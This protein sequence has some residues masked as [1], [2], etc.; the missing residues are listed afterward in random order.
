MDNTNRISVKFSNKIKPIEAINSEFTLCKCYV[1]GCG[2]NRNLT[3]M[4]KENV[5]KFKGT[6]SYTPVVGHLFKDDECNLHMGGHD[7]TFD[8]NFN[9]VALTVPFGVVKADSFAYETV[10][11]YGTDFEY[12][13]ADIVLWTGRYPELKEAIYNDETWFNQSMEISVSQYRPLEEDSNYTELLDW[14]YSALCLLG[15]SDKPE[16]NV[17]PCFIN[18]KVQ[19]Y[20][21]EL[22]NEFTE[23][24]AEMK[25]AISICFSSNAGGEKENMTEERIAEIL[26][27]YEITKEDLDFEITLEMSEDEIK[28]KIEAFKCKDK[29]KKFDEG[30]TE[31]VATEENPKE[32]VVTVE[33]PNSKYS[34]TA[35]Q[36]RDLI[37]SAL[38]KTREFD[39]DGN[40]TFA[41]YYYVCDFDDTYVYVEKDEY[42]DGD[43]KYEYGRLSY[44]VADDETTATVNEDFEIMIKVWLTVEE[45]EKIQAERKN[46]E[47]LN[48]ELEELRA[49][50]ADVEKAEADAKK[51][52]EEAEV[53][54]KFDEKLADVKEYAELKAHSADYEISALEKECYALVG[55]YAFTSPKTDKKEETTAEPL[56]FSVTKPVNTKAKPYGDVFEKYGNKKID[57]DC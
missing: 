50:K 48:A 38:K 33:N 56:K 7:Y 20:Q 26:A 17:E 49:F 3:Y 30:E 36:K 10:N 40:L 22:N 34:V 14:E 25:E 21:F 53:F 51:T 27:E 52:A 37:Q 47:L 11:E 43:W 31:E 9:F 55:M 46:F 57:E 29:K 54:A 42:T 32:V 18:S 24:F 28:E 15:K 8:D 12:L 5:E 1:Q 19:P 41:V 44:T 6:L 39:E 2:K 16:E 35:N 4:S 13:T 23:K 45:N